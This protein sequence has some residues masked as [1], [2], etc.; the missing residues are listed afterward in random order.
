M[1]MQE[2]KDTH[3]AVDIDGLK[4]HALEQFDVHQY[5]EEIKAAMAESTPFYAKK[6]WRKVYNIELSNGMTVFV[7]DI[8][9]SQHD[10]RK[11]IPFLGTHEPQRYFRN[12]QILQR[13]GIDSPRI[14]FYFGQRKGCRWQRSVLCTSDLSGYLSFQAYFDRHG[15]GDATEILKALCQ[16]TLKLH[17]AGYTFSMDRNNIFVREKFSGTLDD[18]ALID[19]DHLSKEFF[20]SLSRRRRRRALRRFSGT[21]D[22]VDALGGC[23]SFFL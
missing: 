3:I 14:L 23:A 5:W 21:I 4:G 20:G 18:L 6:E 16:L 2:H 7:K 1:T 19:L 10:K 9:E 15:P 22:R 11:V 8:D 13:L 12:Y 17:D